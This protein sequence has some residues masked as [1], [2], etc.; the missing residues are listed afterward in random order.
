MVNKMN[1]I[2]HATSSQEGLCV[3]LFL[4]RQKKVFCIHSSGNSSGYLY[5][6]YSVSFYSFSASYPYFAVYVGAYCLLQRENLQDQCCQAILLLF[7]SLRLSVP[8]FL[9]TFASLVFASLQEPINSTIWKTL[10]INCQN[11]VLFVVDLS[12]YKLAFFQLSA[13]IHMSFLDCCWK[14]KLL[15]IDIFAAY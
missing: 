5:L 4:H 13:F 3:T 8:G 11:I 14:C 15:A 9:F 10:I 12:P 2:I 7:S 1:K 6:G